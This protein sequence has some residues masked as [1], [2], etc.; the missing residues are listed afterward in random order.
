MLGFA[1]AFD[2]SGLRPSCS[3]TSTP[4]AHVQPT[5]RPWN[6]HGM[7]L[8]YSFP[9]GGRRKAE[10]TTK[11]VFLFF[12]V[13]FL[14]DNNNRTREFGKF[15]HLFLIHSWMNYF[16]TLF[17]KNR[18]LYHFPSCDSEECFTSFPRTTTS[19]ML[20]VRL[21]TLWIT[22]TFNYILEVLVWCHLRGLVY[23]FS[24]SSF[25]TW[26][27]LFYVCVHAERSRRRSWNT[28]CFQGTWKIKKGVVPG[29]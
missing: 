9:R 27:F 7:Y 2:H 4:P 13:S 22:L 18:L 21:K 6:L 19:L 15:L 8:Y 11:P 28:K 24:L 20:E 10:L 1:F 29:L 23:L 3:L 5:Y 12:R 16:R 17:I 14:F 26:I 25:W